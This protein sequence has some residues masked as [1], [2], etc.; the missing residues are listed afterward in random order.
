MREHSYISD[1]YLRTETIT[2]DFRRISMNTGFCEFLVNH[3]IAVGGW[4]LCIYKRQLESWDKGLLGQVLAAN[5][6][7]YSPLDSIQLT[8]S[9]HEILVGLIKRAVKLPRTHPGGMSV[10]LQSGRIRV[11]GAFFPFRLK[12]DSGYQLLFRSRIMRLTVLIL[13]NLLNT[14]LFW[15]MW[16]GFFFAGEVDAVWYVIVIHLTVVIGSFSF[17]AVRNSLIVESTV[18]WQDLPSDIDRKEFTRLACLTA[19]YGLACVNIVVVAGV[20]LMNGT[21]DIW[22]SG[23][24]A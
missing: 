2:D 13:L 9:G 1:E 22:L 23:G 6:G 4:L 3:G 16:K 21:I 12:P 7:M 11:V 18:C 24:Q 10:I 15:A 5:W 14:A 8:R 20:Y 17:Y 19:A